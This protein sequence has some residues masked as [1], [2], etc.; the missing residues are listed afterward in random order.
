MYIPKHFEPGDEAG[1]VFL[2]AINAGHLISYTTA[3]IVSTFIP[4]LFQ[5]S[6]KSIVGHLARGNQQWSL[7]TSVDALFIATVNDAYISPSWYASKQEHGKVVPTWDYMTAHVYGELV[8]HDDVSW[9]RQQV[10]ALTNKFEATRAKPWKLDDAPE[11][12]VAGQLRAIVG[13]ELKVSRI[14]V[15]FKM[16]QNKTKADLDGVIAGLLKDG[17]TNISDKVSELRPLDKK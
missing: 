7:E 12:Y 8:I 2:R 4:V 3:G 17:K 13:V 1:Q 16:S 14:E 15:S 10:S 5:E 9:L 6:T 11:D